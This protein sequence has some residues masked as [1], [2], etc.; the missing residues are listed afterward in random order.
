MSRTLWGKL[1][2]LAKLALQLPQT[3]EFCLP[4]RYA[5]Q[6][7]RMLA[8][9]EL[10]DEGADAL[11][12][13]SLIRFRPGESTLW[14]GP[15]HAGKTTAVSECQVAWALAGKHTVFCSLED[16]SDRVVARWVRQVIGSKT[17][18]IPESLTRD[19]LELLNEHMTLLDVH[20]RVEPNEALA[21]MYYAAREM[22]AQ[23]F[24][25]DNLTMVVP[26][27]FD[28]DV[29]LQQFVCSAH[30]IARATGMHVHLV[31]HIRKPMDGKMPNRYD[32]RGTGSA[33]DQVDNV[34]MIWRDEKGE[35]DESRHADRP[36]NMLLVDKQRTTGQRGMISLWHH[37][38]SLQFTTRPADEP[39]CRL[40][41]GNGEAT[42]LPFLH[43]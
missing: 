4:E 20:G 27:G 34:V 1:P 33:S 29:V 22:Q 11:P 16:A 40:R 43:R 12:Y 14:A 35:L 9:P 36:E 19:A 5:D 18:R 42:V 2:D 30:A 17:H 21:I 26:L 10:I 25:L 39:I 3:R 8:H 31:A 24:V 6:V 23:H 7:V 13:G 41:R 15:N 38:C 28:T 37:G 32:I